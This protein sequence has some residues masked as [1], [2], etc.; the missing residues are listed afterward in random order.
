MALQLFRE[1]FSL[2]IKPEN[3]EILNET[4]L[5][6]SKGGSS[7]RAFV[8]L[9]N[10][11][12]GKYTEGLNGRTYSKNLWS[13]CVN[14]GMLEGI[15]AINS[16]LDN[17]L[18]GSDVL[19]LWK[20][21]RITEECPIADFY[22]TD[23]RLARNLVEGIRTIGISTSGYGELKEG[24][25]LVDEQTF[26]PVS[27]DV[28]FNPSMEVYLSNERIGETTKDSKIKEQSTNKESTN[29]DNMQSFGGHTIMSTVDK[30]T[31]AQLKNNIKTVITGAKSALKESTIEKISESLTNIEG[32]ME[33]LSDAGAMPDK[34]S[35]MAKIRESLI[36]K[37]E[38]SYAAKDKALTE[39]EQTVAT[40]KKEN[41]ELVAV[42]EA[43][44][45]DILIA[46][47]LL[48]DAKKVKE[49]TESSCKE[50]SQ[51][52]K[53]KILE[54]NQQFMNL[55]EDAL[56]L[57]NL[58]FS[59]N[60]QLEEAKVNYDK[61]QKDLIEATQLNLF[62]GKRLQSIDKLNKKFKEEY[63]MDIYAVDSDAFDFA[64]TH[65]GSGEQTIAIDPAIERLKDTIENDPDY[66]VIP[67]S[68]K[69]EQNN[70]LREQANKLKVLQSVESAIQANASLV[71][72]K[73]SLLASSSA[74]EVEDK[75][76]YL[77]D[78]L[79]EAGPVKLKEE[80]E[81]SFSFSALND[82]Y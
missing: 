51:N 59:L 22:V 35:E 29:I 55:R 80:N 79:K 38:E 25:S 33:I 41:M 74:K 31:E 73:E 10:Q 65:S 62:L 67:E 11:P 3:V 7:L 37:I 54:N 16:H 44:K 39:K 9:K 46:N 1:N 23:E 32:Y 68:R 49:E 64:T 70:R 81:V 53:S 15:P 5:V 75:V 66:A 58:V 52:L 72:V 50:S 47:S 24:T 61:S 21:H 43:Q 56:V 40:L 8:I 36:E 34:L 69:K 71:H 82:A 26:Q 19:G 57:K 18:P 60:E 27:I 6:E 2:A 14:E 77:E 28:V 30:L 4:K 13:K 45:R 48:E 17:P 20:N 78:S 12:Y 63:D 76:K 42:I